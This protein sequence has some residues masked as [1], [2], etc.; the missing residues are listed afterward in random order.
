[1][2]SREALAHDALAQEAPEGARDRT[3]EI[4]S[5]DRAITRLSP[6][7]IALWTLR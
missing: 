7:S 1:L 4:T 2:H 6:F 5:M 3:H